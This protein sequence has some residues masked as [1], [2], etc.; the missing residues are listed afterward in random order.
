MK[1]FFWNPIDKYQDELGT[2]QLHLGALWYSFV[3]IQHLHSG[4]NEVCIFMGH[5]FSLNKFLRRDATLFSTFS[6]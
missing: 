1:A 2:D 5:D 4:G 3:N 6:K